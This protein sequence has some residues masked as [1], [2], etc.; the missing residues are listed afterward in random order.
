MAADVSIKVTGMKELSRAFKTFGDATLPKG[1]RDA[2][3]SAVEVVAADARRSVPVRSGRLKGSIKTSGTQR[4]GAVTAGSSKVRYAKAI[5]F[6]TGARVGK[7][8]PHNIVGR[9]FLHNAVK[10]QRDKVAEVYRRQ[11]RGLVE[12]APWPKG[13]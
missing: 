12:R 4:G 9:P 11:I 5:E 1:V 2:H 3:K 10:A 13:R 7:R 6:G 8:G